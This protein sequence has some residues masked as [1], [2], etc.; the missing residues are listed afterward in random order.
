MTAS[1]L[2]PADDL[3]APPGLGQPEDRLPLATLEARLAALEKTLPPAL[4]AKV[5]RAML[6]RRQRRKPS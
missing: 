3:V 6:G 1:N 5:R 2:P 4:A